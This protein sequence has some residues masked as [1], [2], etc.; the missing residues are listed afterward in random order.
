MQGTLTR[1]AIEN[2]AKKAVEAAKALGK[3]ASDVRIESLSFN[4]S[5]NY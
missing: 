1:M 5:G 2:A 3:T 4:G